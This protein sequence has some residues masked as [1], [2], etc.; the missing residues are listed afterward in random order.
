MWFF[1]NDNKLYILRYKYNG[2]PHT[3]IPSEKKHQWNF[4]FGWL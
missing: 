3:K 2:Y 4:V 1:R